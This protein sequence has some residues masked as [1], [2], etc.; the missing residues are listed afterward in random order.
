MLMLSEAEGCRSD[1]LKFSLSG[2]AISY[3]FSGLCE[4][5]GRAKRSSSLREL[6]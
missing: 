6:A 4:H 2:S 5:E 3:F 1:S